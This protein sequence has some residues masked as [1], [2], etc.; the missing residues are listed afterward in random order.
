MRRT[1]TKE[2]RRAEKAE[3]R[4]R[5][6]DRRERMMAGEEGYLLPVIAAP[7]GGSSAISWMP[8]ATSSVCSCRPPCS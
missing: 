4:S 3:R 5:M 6:N 7:S 1:L 2:E 8:D